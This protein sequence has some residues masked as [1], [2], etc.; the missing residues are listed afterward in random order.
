MIWLCV[1]LSQLGNVYHEDPE[2]PPKK[3]ANF[4]I[5]RDMLQ[6]NVW[7]DN[8]EYMGCNDFDGSNT[9]KRGIDLKQYFS[10][11]SEPTSYGEF[12]I[13]TD[14]SKPFNGNSYM[15]FEMEIDVI[16]V[17]GGSAV[18]SR[19]IGS[20]TAGLDT[21]LIIKDES[22]LKNLTADTIYR[23]YVVVVNMSLN[24]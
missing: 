10:K 19:S 9:P 7:P 20:W 1:L 5:C 17:H 13:I 11:V 24:E 22:I 16:Q 6:A 23:I 3:K 18:N 2:M 12:E 4:F 8:L 14:T 15:R 21:P